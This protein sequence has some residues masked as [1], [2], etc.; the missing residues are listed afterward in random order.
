VGSATETAPLAVK[1]TISDGVAALS[2]WAAGATISSPA[3]RAV[4]A[5]R[6]SNLERRLLTASNST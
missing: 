2:L 3:M 1:V 5:T 6:Y 4:G